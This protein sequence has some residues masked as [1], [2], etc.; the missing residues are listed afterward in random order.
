MDEFL[1][2]NANFIR[3][4]EDWEKYG[5]ITVG[6]DFDGTVNDY[7]K[8]GHTYEQVKTLLRELKELKCTLICWTAYHDL[9]FVEDFLT[10]EKIPFDGINTCGIKLPW[11]S[12][13][14]FFSSLLDDRAGLES[15]YKDLCLL[16]WYVK[17]HLK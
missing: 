9:A 15:A 7:H 5:S 2:P 10:N 3:L 1:K 12:K 8:K 4:V 6:F 16:V 11:D 14:P 17:K 13:K